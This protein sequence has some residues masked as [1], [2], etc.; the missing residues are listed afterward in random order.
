MLKE[1][2]LN[3]ELDCKIEMKETIEL[4]RFIVKY[5]DQKSR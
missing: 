3:K 4:N 2:R 1:D 5:R